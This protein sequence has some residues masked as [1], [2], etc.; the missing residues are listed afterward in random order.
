M[1]QHHVQTRLPKYLLD[2][3]DVLAA[4]DLDAEIEGPIDQFVVNIGAH[5]GGLY[6]FVLRNPTLRNTW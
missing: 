1:V 5:K 4:R 6:G 3:I 2:A